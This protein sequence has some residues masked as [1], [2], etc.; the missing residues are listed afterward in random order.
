MQGKREYIGK[1]NHDNNFELLH[2]KT[3]ASPGEQFPTCRENISLF[4]AVLPGI[5]MFSAWRAIG[6]VERGG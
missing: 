5:C 1:I 4:L 6:D 2:E 3:E